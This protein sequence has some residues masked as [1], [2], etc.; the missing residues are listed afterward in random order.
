MRCTAPIALRARVA[1]TVAK[2]RSEPDATAVVTRASAEPTWMP[3]VEAPARF[4]V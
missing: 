2:S 4:S 1:S 3:G